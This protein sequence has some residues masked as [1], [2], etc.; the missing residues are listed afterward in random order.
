MSQDWY[1]QNFTHSEVD[2]SCCGKQNMAASTMV[3]FQHARN[4][5]GRAIYFRSGSRCEKHN[6]EV[7]GASSSSHIFTE[8][9]ESTAG[10]VTLST[11]SDMTS[12]ELIKLLSAL[13][14]VGFRRIGISYSFIHA[15]NDPDKSPALWL[16]IQNR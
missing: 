7:G 14:I 15:D 5:V 10:D 6:I 8:Q 9:R 2:C 4:L 12:E 1:C 11:G 16:Y 13:I 3:M